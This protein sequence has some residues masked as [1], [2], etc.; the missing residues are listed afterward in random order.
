M[1]FKVHYNVG[2][3]YGTWLQVPVGPRLVRPTL[4]GAT[5]THIITDRVG[6]VPLLLGTSDPIGTTYNIQT[7]LTV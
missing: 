7:T 6:P 1:T 4:V 2:I 3:S 5:A